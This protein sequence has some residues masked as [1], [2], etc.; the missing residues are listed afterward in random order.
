MGNAQCQRPVRAQMRPEMQISQPLGSRGNAG[1]HDHDLHAA[2]FPV[3]NFIA[4]NRIAGEEAVLAPADH[5]FGIRQVHAHGSA[6]RDLPGH[7]ARGEAGAGFGPVVLGAE[8][9]G[10][11]PQ[12]EAVIFLV[13]GI[14]GSLVSAVIPPYLQELFTDQVQGFI[15][16]DRFELSLTA[17]TDPLQR[18]QDTVLAVD[19]LPVAG[20]LGAEMAVADGEA[21]RAFYLE[22]LSV[23]D[24][25]VETALH[26]GCADVAHGV[27]DFN[28]AVRSRNLAVRVINLCHDKSPPVFR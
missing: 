10:E 20:S 7:G 18:G 16:G 15:P 13:A 1:I 11:P 26:A 19:E 22:D 3:G 23:L 27:A 9:P 17:L 6:G 28:A 4:D 14:E 2:L 12:H 8:D 5:Q 25:D 21:F 24:Q